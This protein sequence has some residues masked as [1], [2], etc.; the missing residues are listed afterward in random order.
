MQRNACL[1]AE[2]RINLHNEADTP[3]SVQK[4][5]GTKNKM[6]NPK[7]HDSLFKWLITAFTREFFEH[8]LVSSF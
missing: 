2:R 6:I 8:Y 5:I 3:S 1:D 7:S 4:I